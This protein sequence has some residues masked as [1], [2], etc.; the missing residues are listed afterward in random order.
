M[1]EPNGPKANNGEQKQIAGAVPAEPEAATSALQ[2]IATA[3]R[4][5]ACWREGWFCFDFFLFFSL[6]EIWGPIG[7]R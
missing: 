6:T 5:A 7:V 1:S 2:T 4:A 3:E